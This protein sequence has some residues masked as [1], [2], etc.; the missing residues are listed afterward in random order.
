MSL[1]RTKRN[2]LAFVFTT[3]S[4]VRRASLQAIVKRIGDHGREIIPAVIYVASRCED[5]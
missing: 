2:G 1:V 4:V 5:P 3:E